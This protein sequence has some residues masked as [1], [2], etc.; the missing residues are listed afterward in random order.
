MAE[1]L[2]ENPSLNVSI[3]ACVNFSYSYSEEK[4]AAI[5]QRFS[6]NAD[7][8]KNY[9]YGKGVKS[10]QLSSKLI[11][12]SKDNPSISGTI[13]RDY[14]GKTSSR[15]ELEVLESDC[16]SEIEAERFFHKNEKGAIYILDKV[17]F[18]PDSPELEQRSFEELDRLSL[19]LTQHTTIKIRINGHTDIG[20]ANGS[21]EFLQKLSD[22]RARAVADYLISKGADKSTISY[23]GFANRK[24]IAD[25][26]TEAGKAMNRRVEVEILEF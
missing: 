8:I 26:S 5:K 1:Y 13:G 15:Y 16:K 20:K 19:F 2:K 17:F 24:P 14:I 7:F 25:N 23:Q 6:T 10:N 4:K 12:L 18:A 11:E 22:N 21:D 9:W 3:N